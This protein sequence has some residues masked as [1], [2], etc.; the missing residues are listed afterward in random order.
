MCKVVKKPNIKLIISIPK[1][2]KC[3]YKVT[4]LSLITF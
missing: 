4:W 2:M 3:G 1:F